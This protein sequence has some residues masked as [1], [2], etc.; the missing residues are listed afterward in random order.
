[1]R[2]GSLNWS[3]PLNFVIIASIP[4]KLSVYLAAGEGNRV[5]NDQAQKLLG[6]SSYLHANPQGVP[7]LRA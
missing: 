6:L 3:I 4:S 1:M 5:K 2:L 7:A